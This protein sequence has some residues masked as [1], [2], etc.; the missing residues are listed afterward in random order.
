V[1]NPQRPTRPSND[2]TR[3]AV[4][5]LRGYA[6]Q[7]WQSLFGWLGLRDGEIL[8]LEGAEDIDL[9]RGSEVVTSQ[10]RIHARPITLNTQAIRD[11]IRAL[12]VSCPAQSG[13]RRSVPLHRPDHNR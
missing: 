8:F 5:S 9:L 1:S 6:Y 3:E 4:E 11:A 7:L 13:S 12:L 10:T 2:P